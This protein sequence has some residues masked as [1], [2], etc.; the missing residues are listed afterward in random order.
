MYIPVLDPS[1]RTSLAILDPSR[2][3]GSDI[4]KYHIV[5]FI[6]IYIDIYIVSGLNPIWLL[7][8]ANTPIASRH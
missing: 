2:I 6:Y 3:L 8:F 5:A 1:I 4:P 7:K